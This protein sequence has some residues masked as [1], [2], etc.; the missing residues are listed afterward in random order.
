MCIPKG[1]FTSAGRDHN[2]CLKELEG[3][4]VNVTEWYGVRTLSTITGSKHFVISNPADRYGSIEL[5]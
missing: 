1:W 5:P 3:S 4:S 2:V